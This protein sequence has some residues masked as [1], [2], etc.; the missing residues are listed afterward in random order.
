MA[1]CA[2]CSLQA[3]TRTSGRAAAGLVADL[4]KL[5]DWAAW[6]ADGNPA[7]TDR[8]PAVLTKAIRSVGKV[9]DRAAA[10]GPETDWALRNLSAQFRV[11]LWLLSAEG[12][13]MKCPA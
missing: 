13:N 9:A 8:T 7:R 1:K 2:G 4:R 5:L 11:P 6:R 3:A 12:A 10:L